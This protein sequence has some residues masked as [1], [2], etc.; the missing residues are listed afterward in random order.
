ML[1][2]NF[3]DGWTGSLNGLTIRAP[4]GANKLGKGYFFPWTSLAGTCLKLQSAQ[5]FCPKNPMMI[6]MMIM[7]MMMMIMITTT[8]E[9]R[10]DL[11]SQVV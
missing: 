5:F 10:F 6:M 2:E 9:N 3:A 1:K 7:M 8:G 4:N 11:P